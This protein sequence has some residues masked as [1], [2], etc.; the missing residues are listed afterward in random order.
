MTSGGILF[1]GFIYNNASISVFHEQEFIGLTAPSVVPGRD[2]DRLGI[3]FSH[4]TFSFALRRGEE[5][6][7]AAGLSPGAGLMGPQ[8]DEGIME[9]YYGAAVWR[10]MLFQP[11]Y[12]YVVHPGGSTHIRNASV[13]GFKA[14]A[15][16]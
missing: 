8:S 11:E 4:Y 16:L 6:R 7:E 1:G 5:L 2:H 15:L 9:V 12:E 14:T 10:G 3:V 13:I